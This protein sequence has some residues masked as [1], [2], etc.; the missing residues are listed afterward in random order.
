MND[1]DRE[2]NSKIHRMLESRYFLEFIDK[3]LKQ[4]KLY[5]Y[6]D[7][8]DLVVKA[9]E[10]TLEKIRSGKIVENFDAW[11]KTICFNVIRNFAKKTK[12]QN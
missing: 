1:F 9:R 10:I 12:S 7:V 6:Y 3:K 4:F 11:F 5:S 8:M 2:L